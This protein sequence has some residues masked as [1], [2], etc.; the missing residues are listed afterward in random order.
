MNS[1]IQNSVQELQQAITASR[2]NY[3][4][5][6][7]YKEKE[8]R[9]CYVDIL[10]TYP[11]FFQTSLHAHFVAMIVSL[12]RLYETRKDTVNLPQL[13]KLLKTQD[14]IPNEKLE[15]IEFEI[16]K[17]KPLWV[18]VS[19]LRNKMFGHRS[20]VLDHGAIWKEAKVKP[21]QLKQLID[22]SKRILN[23]ITLLW[24]R[25]PDDFNR[26]STEDTLN[27]LKDLKQLRELKVSG[28]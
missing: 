7:I 15:R 21:D 16:K 20:N 19:V 28:N 9:K 11:L 3:E 8:N 13:I 22:E 5:W 14:S 4:I 6:W 12:Y 23:E 17:I 27:L 25:S 2:L 26:S 24:N 18:K 10:N 1:E